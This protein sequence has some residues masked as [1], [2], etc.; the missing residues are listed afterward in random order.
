M[1]ESL[2]NIRELLPIQKCIAG[3]DVKNLPDA[4]LLA[5]ILGTGSRELM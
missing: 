2:K 3:E 4:E 1:K 5:I